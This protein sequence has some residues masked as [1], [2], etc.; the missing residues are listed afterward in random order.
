M[1]TDQFPLVLRSLRMLE[2]D[3]AIEE[4]RIDEAD[5]REDRATRTATAKANLRGCTALP[6][7]GSV[8]AALETVL[9]CSRGSGDRGSA[10]LA[11]QNLV[12]ATASRPGRPAATQTS[13]DVVQASVE[14][15]TASTRL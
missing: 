10:G 6:A 9:E 4:V 12:T 5:S 11:L 13:E 3:S 14:A 2:S 7:V 15:R 1:P 8:A